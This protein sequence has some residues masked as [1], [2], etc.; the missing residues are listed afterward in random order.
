MVRNKCTPRGKPLDRFALRHYIHLDQQVANRR[1][2]SDA[3]YKAGMP[4]VS[5]DLAICCLWA[6][7]TGS[8][9]DGSLDNA[10]ASLRIANANA[11][12]EQVQPTRN[13]GDP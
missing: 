2:D 11:K 7:G 6:W 5:V 12:E 1:Y 9:T 3:P 10:H 4:I 13:P 8:P